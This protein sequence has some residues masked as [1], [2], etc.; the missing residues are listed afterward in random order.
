MSYLNTIRPNGHSAPCLSRVNRGVSFRANYCP[1]M[2]SKSYAQKLLDPRWSEFRNEFISRHTVE[3][4]PPNCAS[5]GESGAVQIHHR[6]YHR[7][8]EP[9]EYEDND[10][11]LICN[12]CHERVHAV[13]REFGAWLIAIPPHE[14][15]EAQDLLEELVRCAE[16]A[17]A[18]AH[19]KN[20]ARA[21]NHCFK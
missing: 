8:R 9:W 7:G 14:I 10:L 20:A 11:V 4:D 18:L 15:H 6:R 17:I 16:P 1:E 3:G 19:C 12:E 5:C 21:V 2:T 13:A